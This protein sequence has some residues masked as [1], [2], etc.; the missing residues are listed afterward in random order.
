MTKDQ[1]V[2]ENQHI[3][4]AVAV[5]RRRAE[6]LQSLADALALSLVVSRLDEQ[7]AELEREHGPRGQ[8]NQPKQSARHES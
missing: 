3:R 5:L 8:G 4:A 7:W 2:L 6:R 1:L